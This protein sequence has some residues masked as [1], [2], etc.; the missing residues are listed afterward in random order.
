VSSGV[1][2]AMSAELSSFTRLR[3]ADFVISPTLHGRVQVH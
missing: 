1:V 2:T 3:S